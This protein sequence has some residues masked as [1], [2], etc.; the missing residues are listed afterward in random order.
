M[1]LQGIVDADY[2]FVDVCIGGVHNACVLVHSPI[3]HQITKNNLLPNNTMSV[4]GVNIPLYLVGDS[5]P[6]ADIANETFSLAQS[7]HS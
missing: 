5:I 4:N 3:Y 1:I 2:C 6:M 7:T